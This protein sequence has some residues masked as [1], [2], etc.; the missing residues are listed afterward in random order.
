MLVAAAGYGKTTLAEQWARDDGRRTAWFRA[1]RSA[2]DVAVLARGLSAAAREL[3]PGAGLRLEERL[4]VTQDPEREAVVLAEILASDL[5]QWPRD[6][7]IVIDDYQHVC[8]S[9]GRGDGFAA[10]F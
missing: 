3:I 10:G 1:R 8:G 4:A 5:R 6:G 2:I 7:W 9:D